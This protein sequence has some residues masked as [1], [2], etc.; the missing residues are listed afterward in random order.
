MIFLKICKDYRPSGSLFYFQQPMWVAVFGSLLMG[1]CFVSFFLISISPQPQSQ[2]A[3]SISSVS[4][5]FA[6]YLLNLNLNLNLLHLFH[7]RSSFPQ[8]PQG[9]K[10]RKDSFGMT[11]VST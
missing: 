1:D 7:L 8:G 4:S 6:T 3:S 9:S 2:S 10:G 5:A 11:G